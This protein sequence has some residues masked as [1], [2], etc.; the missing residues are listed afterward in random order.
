M[1]KFTATS[2]NFVLIGLGLEPENIERL[3]KGQPIRVKLGDMGFT[4]VLGMTHIMIFTGESKEAMEA[5]LRPLIGPDT[6]VH[7]E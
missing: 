5:E 4:G 3:K 1:I 6:I 2:E 7:R